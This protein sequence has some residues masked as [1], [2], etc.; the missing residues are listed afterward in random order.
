MYS[1]QSP[2]P[3]NKGNSTIRTIVCEDDDESLEHCKSTRTYREEQVNILWSKLQNGYHFA[4]PKDDVKHAL[5]MC[6]GELCGKCY[7]GSFN[8]TSLHRLLL[9][10]SGDTWEKK[11]EHCSDFIHWA[12]LN[13]GDGEN[14]GA[15]LAAEN[16][17]AKEFGCNDFSCLDRTEIYSVLGSFPNS[18]ASLISYFNMCSSVY[19]WTVSRA[20]RKQYKGQNL[21]A[22]QQSPSCSRLT[23]GNLC[24]ELARKSD[25]HSRKR[26]RNVVLEKISKGK[27]P[28]YLI[29]LTLNIYTPGTYGVQYEDHRNCCFYIQGRSRRNKKFHRK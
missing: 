25:N 28:N 3:Q 11:R 21:L 13:F 15:I 12:P 22:W 1:W 6:F 8:Y 29:F 7:K 16:Q 27:K 24:N 20:K 10:L 23:A 2:A 9:S 5:S 26:G 19:I 17:N 4:R 14:V 18:F